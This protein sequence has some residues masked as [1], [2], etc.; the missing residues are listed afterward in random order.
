MLEVDEQ[1]WR[2]CW[3]LFLKRRGRARMVII[4]YKGGEANVR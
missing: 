1:R 4:R 3:Y 2:I